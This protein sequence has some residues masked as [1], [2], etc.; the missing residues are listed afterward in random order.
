MVCSTDTLQYVSDAG[1][2]QGI[3]RVQKSL[4]Q[5]RITMKQSTKPLS[6]FQKPSS[7]EQGIQLMEFSVERKEGEKVNKMRCKV[8]CEPAFRAG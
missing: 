7:Q 5:G 2:K 6:I 8:M 3:D 1:L 4:R